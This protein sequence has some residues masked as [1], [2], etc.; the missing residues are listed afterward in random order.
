MESRGSGDFNIIRD[1]GGI[2]DAGKC[3]LCGSSGSPAYVI[4]HARFIS[5]RRSQHALEG[6]DL[7][8][9]ETGMSLKISCN[10]RY[11]YSSF[12]N[13]KL[14]VEVFSSLRSK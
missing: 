3:V 7:V 11:N 4:T 12:T 1:A 10:I 2:Y 6:A 5:I 8:S 9:A 14:I 13:L